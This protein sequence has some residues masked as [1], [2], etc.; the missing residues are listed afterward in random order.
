MERTEE[1][2]EAI[3]KE[4]KTI[5]EYVEYKKQEEMWKRELVR[6]LPKDTLQFD[7]EKEVLEIRREFKQRETGQD[8]IG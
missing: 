3:L 1:L 6:S 8:H 2:L 7:R 5:S 4:L